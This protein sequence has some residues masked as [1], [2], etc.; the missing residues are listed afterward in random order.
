MSRNWWDLAGIDMTGQKK[1]TLEKSSMALGIAAVI[2][3]GMPSGM[4]GVDVMEISRPGGASSIA[5]LWG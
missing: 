1:L 5:D 4:D 3:T 2:E